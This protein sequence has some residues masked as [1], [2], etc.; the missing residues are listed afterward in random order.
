MAKKILVVEDEPKNL[1]LIHDL[2][3]RFGY[4]VNEAT[5]GIRGLEMTKAGDPDLVLMDIM[6]PRMN[7]LEA[8]R[9][10]KS[11]AST[12][13]IPV[14]ALTAF[15]MAGDREQAI[16]AGCDGYISK[17]VDIRELLETIRRFLS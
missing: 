14:I 9:I 13:N 16:E 4:E 11:N 2:L 5:D 7:G 8:T 10:I 3:Q 15:A 1:K 6:M 12:K 17:P